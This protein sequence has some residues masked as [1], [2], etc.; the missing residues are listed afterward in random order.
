MTP[1]GTFDQ[2][3][4]PFCLDQNWDSRYKGQHERYDSSAL[5]LEIKYQTPGFKYRNC[6]S[7]SLLRSNSFR[8]GSQLQ[9]SDQLL[10]GCSGPPSHPSPFLLPGLPLREGFPS[11]RPCSNLLHLAHPLNLLCF[12]AFNSCDMLIFCLPCPR[13]Q[14]C[15][16]PSVIDLM[17]WWDYHSH[18][19]LDHLCSHRK[20]EYDLD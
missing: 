6:S 15:C 3:G 2:V 16:S 5:E 9:I 19:N 14:H 7:S 18:R 17:H 11:C 12:Q 13:L 10:G 1:F 8:T 4:I 20:Q